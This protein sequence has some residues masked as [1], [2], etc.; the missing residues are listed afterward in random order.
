[1]SQDCVVNGLP[2]DSEDEK[3]IFDHDGEA[4]ALHSFSL[5]RLQ[6]FASQHFGSSVKLHKLAEGGFHKVSL[7]LRIVTTG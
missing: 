3:S 6:E 5:T 4:G 7:W 2:I 1:M